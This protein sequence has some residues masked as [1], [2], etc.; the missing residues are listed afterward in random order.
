MSD[1]LLAQSTTPRK[2]QSESF[3]SQLL[4]EFSRFGERGEFRYVNAWLLLILSINAEVAVVQF[5]VDE[6]LNTRFDCKTKR[7]VKETGGF[8]FW[9]SLFQSEE[10]Q[11]HDVKHNKAD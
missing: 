1:I 8:A 9:T 10:E 6:N 7:Q 2:P 5:A 4:R 3:A 11:N